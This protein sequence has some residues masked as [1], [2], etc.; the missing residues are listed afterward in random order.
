MVYNIIKDRS[1]IQ[2]VLIKEYHK[3]RIRLN[4]W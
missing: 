2:M 4:K 1:E 3:N